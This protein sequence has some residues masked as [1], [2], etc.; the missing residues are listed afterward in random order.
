MDQEILHPAG[1]VVAKP[2]VLNQYT[3]LQNHLFIE[4]ESQ[5][6]DEMRSV[7]SSSPARGRF[8]NFSTVDLASSSTVHFGRGYSISDSAKG[9]FSGSVK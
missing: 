8:R 3:P 7:A 1:L 6:F 9:L 4:D 2:E 5:N